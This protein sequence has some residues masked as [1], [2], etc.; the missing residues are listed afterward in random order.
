MSE[1]HTNLLISQPQLARFQGKPLHTAQ[2][3]VRGKGHE[4]HEFRERHVVVAG[5]QGLG[6]LQ[7]HPEETKSHHFAARNQQ[8]V[9]HQSLYLQDDAHIR[10]IG[11]RANS[12]GPCAAPRE[13]NAG[14]V[15]IVVGVVHFR[16]IATSH[17]DHVSGHIEGSMLHHQPGHFQGRDLRGNPPRVLLTARAVGLIQPRLKRNP[18]VFSDSDVADAR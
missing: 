9:V 14:I 16:D 2:R 17:R 5:I 8:A 11:V 6:V 10:S 18:M 12:R 4:P 3:K 7:T 13:I 1:H 15:G